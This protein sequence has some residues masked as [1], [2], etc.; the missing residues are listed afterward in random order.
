MFWCPKTG[1][2]NKRVRMAIGASP[3]HPLKTPCRKLVEALHF[4]L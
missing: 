2:Y 4:L 1:A 3:P